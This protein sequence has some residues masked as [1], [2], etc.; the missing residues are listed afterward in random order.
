MDNYELSIPIGEGHYGEVLGQLLFV[1]KSVTRIT[2][3]CAQDGITSM[4]H[5]LLTNKHMKNSKSIACTP[6]INESYTGGGSASTKA[7]I[8]E[9][10]MAHLIINNDLPISFSDELNKGHCF[11]PSKIDLEF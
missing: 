7:K 10:L 11:V 2:Y 1:P 9:L 4:K 3:S 6:K 5:H 8:V